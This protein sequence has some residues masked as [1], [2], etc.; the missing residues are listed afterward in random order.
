MPSNVAILGDSRL[1][2]TYYTNDR[3]EKRYGYDKTFPHLWRR[4]VLADLA[5]GY[6]VVHIPDHFR[7]G[8]V[9]NNIVRLALSDPAVVVILDGIWETLLNKRHFLE[10]AEQRARAYDPAGAEPGTLSY[11]QRAL[12]DLFKTGVLSVSPQRFTDRSRLLV[13]YFRRRRRQVIWMTLPVPPKDYIGST[14]HAGNYR[15]IPDWDECLA[16][17]ND[18]VVPIMERYGCSILDLTQLMNDLGGP[19]AALID[20]WHF[21]PAFH[22]RLADVLHERCKVL[23]AETPSPSHVSHD[24]ILGA[25]EDDVPDTV[26]IHE[27]QASDELDAIAMLSPEQILLYPSELKG[28]DNPRGEDRAEFERHA[29]R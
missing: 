11:S 6:D 29:V 27:G 5:A 14:Y 13:S 28:I 9:Q 21:S 12:V 7:G 10:Y 19:N 20:Q 15:P 23:L 3:Y 25:P 8:T 17:M 1:F 4:K 16:A 22:A 2:D 18:A 24:Y 26:V